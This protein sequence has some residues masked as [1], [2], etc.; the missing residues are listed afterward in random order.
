MVTGRVANLNGNDYLVQTDMITPGKLTAVNRDTIEDMRP[1]TRSPM[2]GDLLD[3]F[4]ESDILD[5][6]AFLRSAETPAS[7]PAD[8]R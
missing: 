4:S 7:E 8:Q 2:P 6:L 5:L 1:S 3:T